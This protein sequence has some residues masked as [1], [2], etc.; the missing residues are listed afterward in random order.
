[1]RCAGLFIGQ[2]YLCFRFSTIDCLLSVASRPPQSK[3]LLQGLAHRSGSRALG[4]QRD[5][6]S[7]QM[8]GCGRWRRRSRRLLRANSGHSPRGSQRVKFDPKATVV[9]VATP[10]EWRLVMC[11]VIT[12]WCRVAPRGRSLQWGANP[13]CPS[14]LFIWPPSHSPRYARRPSPN[15]SKLS[16]RRIFMATSPPRGKS[17]T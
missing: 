9:E 10:Y 8:G 15:Q 16:L 7:S 13:L 3:W 6:R 5:Q 11:I 14:N 2:A 12:L 1:M 4:H 17:L